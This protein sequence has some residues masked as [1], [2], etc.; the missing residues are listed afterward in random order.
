MANL[1]DLPRI[2]K[3]PGGERCKVETRD[4]LERA[5]ADGW[6]V[7]IDPDPVPG[8]ADPASPPAKPLS[9]VPPAMVAN[10]KPAHVSEPH[11]PSVLDGP[12]TAVAAAVADL[13]DLRAVQ[14][15]RLE[16]T[17]GKNRKGALDLLD[18]K[19]AELAE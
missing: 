14:A 13:T 9:P 11:V 15:L 18:A 1:D 4:E 7:H 5:M 16:E 6:L 12:V 19:I 10:Q 17:K 3:K 2:L 8:D